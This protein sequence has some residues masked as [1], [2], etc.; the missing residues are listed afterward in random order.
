MYSSMSSVNT[1]KSN[2]LFSGPTSR[3]SFLAAS[4]PL[5]I[6]ILS[7]ISKL[8]SW[9]PLSTEKNKWYNFIAIQYSYTAKSSIVKNNCVIWIFTKGCARIIITTYL[10][11]P[12]SIMRN[13][14]FRKKKLDQ[15]SEF[16]PKVDW[17]SEAKAIFLINCEAKAKRKRSENPN[18]FCESASKRIRFA[19]Q[20]FAIKR[21]FSPVRN[22]F[23]FAFGFFR[24]KANSHCELGLR[25]DKNKMF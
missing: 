8:I 19:S 14:L 2:T 11:F 21:K 25:L 15:G 17:E 16:R 6:V 9:Y 12:V 24:N 1:S 20:F 22:F 18:S 4:S 13:H 10:S 3:N 5:F 7:L 23:R